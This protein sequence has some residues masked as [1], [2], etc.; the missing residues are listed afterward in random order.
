MIEDVV[1]KDFESSPVQQQ[2]VDE[3]IEEKTVDTSL[4][5][6]IDVETLKLIKPPPEKVNFSSDLSF[7]IL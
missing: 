2:W 5:S 1:E 7:L 3:E 6:E 4:T